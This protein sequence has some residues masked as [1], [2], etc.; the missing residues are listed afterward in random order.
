MHLDIGCVPDFLPPAE[1]LRKILN[2][3]PVMVLFK[4][5]AVSPQIEQLRVRMP[6]RRKKALRKL[7][8]AR[9]VVM[10]GCRQAQPVARYIKASG[11]MH[12]ARVRDPAVPENADNRVIKGAVRIGH[13]AHDPAELLFQIFPVLDNLLRAFYG[14]KLLQPRMGQTVNRNPAVRIE[15]RHLTLCHPAVDL[16]GRIN[17]SLRRVLAAVQVERTFQPVFLHNFNQPGILLHP[18]V[19][20]ERQ[21]PLYAARKSHK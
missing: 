16:S 3:L 8:Q 9:I 19:V 14:G 5:I 20:A 10:A 17:R 2:P 6:E 7:R 1:K 11:G 4:L 13:P 15:L 12:S 21:R 18:V